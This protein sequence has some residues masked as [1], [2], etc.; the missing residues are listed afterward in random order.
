METVASISLDHRKEKRIGFCG[1][2]HFSND[3]EDEVFRHRKRCDEKH[4]AIA[5]SAQPPMVF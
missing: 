3:L 4:V 1:F 5:R 2:G